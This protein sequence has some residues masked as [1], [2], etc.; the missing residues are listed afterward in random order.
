MITFEFQQRECH[1]A[2]A[3]QLLQALA[4]AAQGK[5]KQS[6]TSGP[7]GITQTHHGK[8]QSVQS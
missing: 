1:H 2:A 4:R 6:T 3:A 8:P 7:T 5:R